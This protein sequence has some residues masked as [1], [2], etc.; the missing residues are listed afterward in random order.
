MD[1]RI[2][3]SLLFG[4]PTFVYSGIKDSF[5]LVVLEVSPEICTESKFI[6]LYSEK[7]FYSKM[8]D[9]AEPILWSLSSIYWFS[10]CS[11]AI[12]TAWFNYHLLL[13]I[14]VRKSESMPTK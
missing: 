3:M 8:K 13:L 11:V 6:A 10:T 1:V 14:R 9:K 12:E 4:A 7:W 5:F 2:N